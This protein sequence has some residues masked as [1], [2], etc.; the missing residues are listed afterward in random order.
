V[1]P[2][3]T[4]LSL[5]TGGLPVDT[6]AEIG[7]AARRL[8]EMAGEETAVLVTL[9]AKGALLLDGKEHRDGVLL[10]CPAVE[11]V[12]DTSG[13]GD[14][15]LGSLAAYLSRGVPLREAATRAGRVASLSVQRAGT[16]PSYPQPSELPP[17]LQLP[18]PL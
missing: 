4:E 11:R 16:Q 9:G 18:P 5:L 3:E 14:C 6:E 1:C 7:A 12:V 15:F 17:E 13:A 8:L 2:N 10:P